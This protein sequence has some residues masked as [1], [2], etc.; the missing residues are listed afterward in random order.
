VAAFREGVN[1]LLHWLQRGGHGRKNEY[2]V[3]SIVGSNPEQ[4]IHGTHRAFFVLGTMTIL[5]TIV[6]RELKRGDGDAINQG[7]GAT[8]RV[9]ESSIFELW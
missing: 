4:F 3:R 1:I 5:S 2:S 6:F 8:H 9:V 7:K